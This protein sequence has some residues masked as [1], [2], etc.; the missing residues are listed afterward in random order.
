MK[1]LSYLIAFSVTVLIANQAYAG[2]GNFESTGWVADANSGKVLR[3]LG[4]GTVTECG[5]MQ[6]AFKGFENGN[7]YAGYS[8]CLS[9]CQNGF[10]PKATYVKIGDKWALGKFF[11]LANGTCVQ[12][13]GDNLKYCWQ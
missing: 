7:F 6:G 9:N 4:K 13:N 11:N 12:Q 10:Q 1:N 2:C 8:L 5:N 3:Q